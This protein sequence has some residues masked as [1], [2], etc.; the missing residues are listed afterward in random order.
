M[1]EALLKHAVAALPD[2]DPIKD[3]EIVSAGTSAT[4]GLAPSTNSVNALEKVGIDIS[5][6]RSTQLSQRLL[7]DCFALFAMDESHL[8]FASTSFDNFPKR[9]MTVLETVPDSDKKN[10]PDPYGGDM[11]EY[12]EVRDD[13]IT[14]IPHILKYLKN[15]LKKNS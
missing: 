14:A 7:D 8:D 10:I 12:L 15:E 11:V 3:L 4:P 2:G 13:I 1:G 5:R 6:H 9:A